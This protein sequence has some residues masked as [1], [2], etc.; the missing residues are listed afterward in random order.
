MED[1]V[2][3]LSFAIWVVPKMSEKKLSLLH[4]K[5]SLV[6]LLWEKKFHLLEG[7]IILNLSFLWKLALW[8]GHEWRNICDK[9][10]YF[11]KKY[12]CKEIF[13]TEM[14][15]FSSALHA[16]MPQAHSFCRSQ[17]WD[18]SARWNGVVWLWH[19]IS[20]AGAAWGAH[21][22]SL[23]AQQWCSQARCCKPL[24]LALTK[25][26]IFCRDGSSFGKRQV[27]LKCRKLFLLNVAS[28][29]Y[30]VH[31]VQGGCSCWRRQGNRPDRS[32]FC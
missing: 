8:W 15:V 4:Q 22:N 20:R 25:V 32:L 14:V 7:K 16:E 26:K 23:K 2:E 29:C 11:N 17:W 19:L 27:S 12:F 9:L 21:P 3:Y 24:A 30:R 13:F 28:R 6:E 31:R 1:H 5:E 18:P 10:Q